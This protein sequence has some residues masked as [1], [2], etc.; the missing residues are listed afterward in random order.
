MEEDTILYGTFCLRTY[1]PKKKS[2]PVVKS[3]Q[4]RAAALV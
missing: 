2:V 1:K 4:K 3:I